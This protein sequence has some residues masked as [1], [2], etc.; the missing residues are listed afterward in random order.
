MGKCRDLSERAALVLIVLGDPGS[1]PRTYG[2]YAE[3]GRK[4]PV[5]YAR[6]KGQRSEGESAR[7]YFFWVLRAVLYDRGNW[8]HWREMRLARWADL[9]PERPEEGWTLRSPGR[10]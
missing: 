2:L 1:L 4:L 10:H 3:I 9:V 8:G 7:L 6:E 5:E